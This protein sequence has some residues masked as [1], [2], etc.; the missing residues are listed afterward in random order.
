M[1]HN[2]ELYTKAIEL[3]PT[4][5]ILYAN[6]SACYIQTESYGGAIQDAA[7]AIE[8]DSNYVK[9]DLLQIFSLL[10]TKSINKGFYRRGC[11][12]VSLGKYS[13]ALKDFKQ[14]FFSYL[15]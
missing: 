7:K 11:G 10:K 12:Y 8:L 6:R 3:A 1:H 4:N 15:L 14:V 2:L 9:V 13:E 5:P